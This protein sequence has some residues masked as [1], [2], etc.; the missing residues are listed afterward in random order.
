MQS[1]KPSK[2]RLQFGDDEQVDP[3]VPKTNDKRRKAQ[4][5]PESDRKPSRLKLIDEDTA[6]ATP[7]KPIRK[8]QRAQM[9]ADTASA[10]VAK[11]TVR[12][13]KKKAVAIALATDEATGKSA[14]RLRFDEKAKPPSNLVHEVLRAPIGEVHRQVDKTE[15]GNIGL[16]AIHSL[17]KSAEFTGRFAGHSIR[18]RNQREL[19]VVDKAINNAQKH[20]DKGMIRTIETQSNLSSNPYSRWQQKRAIRKNYIAAKAA[21]DKGGASAIHH[22]TSGLADMGQK[23]KNV[24]IQKKKSFTSIILLIAMI[25][26]ILNGLSSCAPL[27]Q[28]GLQVFVIA[29]YPAEDADILAAER[30]YQAKEKELKKMLDKYPTHSPGYDEYKYELDEIWHDPHA[31]IALISARIGGEW[32]IDDVYG[33]LDILF[34][35]QYTLEELITTETRYKKEWVTHYRQETDP[36]TGIV[37]TVPYQVREDVPYTYSICTVTLDNFNLS[38][39]PFYVLS[40]KAVG[41]Y[42]MY[43]SVLGNREDIFW[44]WPHASTLK[45]YGRHD[46]PEAYLEDEIFA[47]LIEEAEKYLGFPY[48]WG[49]DGPD[50]SFDCSGFVSYVFANSGVRDVGRLGATGLYNRC[51]KITPNEARPGDLIFFEGTIT[52]ED[53]ITH[54]GI[55]VG[56]GWMIHCGSPLGYADANSSYY[57]QHFFGYGRLVQD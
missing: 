40:R 42:A 26:M 9:K 57:R 6:A 45:D 31:L 28:A 46:I 15:D 18:A 12:I 13:P 47:R 33:T 44:G 16:E 14:K 27:I 48:V 29:T 55:Y 7:E 4:P 56:D 53:G 49:G 54:V 11:P 52:G 50:T 23:V 19:R 38:Y 30:A 32:T 36:D 34:E 21:Q 41:M 43:M 3:A 35:R 1:D 8:A 25:A 24:F 39:L 51:K 5:R 37:T 20:L 10:D 2:S 22:A 17:E